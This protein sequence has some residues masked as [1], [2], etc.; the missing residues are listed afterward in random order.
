MKKRTWLLMAVWAL[1]G[2]ERASADAAAPKAD[3]SAR[4]TVQREGETVAPVARG[5]RVEEAA[6]VPSE[7][8]LDLSLPGEVEGSRDAV[9]ASPTGGY[10]E[11]LLV[12]EGQKVR[13]G[14]PIA[15][16]DTS[17]RRAAR[18]Q[19]KAELDLAQS[20]F[21]QVQALGD[22]ASPAQIQQA[23]T[24][25]AVAQSALEMAEIQLRR[26]VIAAPFSGVVAQVQPEVGEVVAPG[27]PVARIVDLDP[28]NVT[29]SISDRDVMSIRPGMEVTVTADARP[30]AVRGK[31]VSV[32]P[33]A[34]LRTRT[35][36][37]KIEVPNPDGAL[38][39]GMIAS[40]R[41][42]RTVG[43][44]AIV[45]PQDALVTQL[46]GIGVFL[47]QGGVA[48]WRPVKVGAVVHDQV[49]IEDGLADG[50]KVIVTGHREL[51]DGDPLIVLRS[52]K[53]CTNG[54]VVF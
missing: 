33:A 32:D 29:V 18:D 53:C 39:P 43:R 38:L 11:A 19:A 52:G 17:V 4:T 12:K 2:C 5:T 9:L 3:A 42:A 22:M 40:V 46:D 30:D 7:A 31:V 49:I 44:N 10:V 54:R 50:E 1:A 27:G 28:V 26:S 51:A 24:Q 23:K 36:T 21:E 45:L 15:R 34:D 25:L 6:I 47:D 48:R 16:I 20:R 37:A 41:L 13:K 14:Q 8:R 35:F